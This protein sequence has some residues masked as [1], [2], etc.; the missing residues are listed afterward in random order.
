[1]RAQDLS[2]HYVTL[3]HQQLVSLLVKRDAERKL[4]L[5][6]ET[7]DI[8]PETVVGDGF[9]TLA[10]QAEDP[11]SCGPAPYRNLVVEGD[12]HVALRWLRMAY[13]GRIGAIIIDPPYNRGKRDLVYNDDYVSQTDRFRSSKW[14]NFLHARFVLARDLLADDG[15]ILVCINDE[16]RAKLELLLDEVFP[17]MRVGSF[18]WRTRG[19]ANEGGDNFFTADHEHVLIY[20][21]RGFRFGGREK[22]YEKYGNPDGDPRGDWRLGDL[23]IGVP[24]DNKRA[25]NGYYPLR[26]PGTGVWYPANPDAVWRY[27]SKELLKP[28]QRLKKQAMED[29]VAEGKVV[30]PKGNRVETWATLEDLYAAID[31]GDVPLNGVGAP[32][33]RRGLPEIEK[34]VGRRVG[35]G[36]PAFKRHKRDLKNQNQ[37]MSSWIRPNA[38]KDAVPADDVTTLTSKYNDEGTSYLKQILGAKVFDYPKPMSL[39]KELVRQCTGPTDIVLDFFGGSGTTGEAVLTV[40]AEDDTDRRFIL[41]S[42]TEATQK[43]PDRNICRDVCAERLRRV[44]EGHGRL[45]GLAGGFGYA[46]ADT[47][48]MESLFWDGLDAAQTWLAIQAIH[49]VDLAPLR[50]GPAQWCRLLDGSFVLYVD[51]MTADIADWAIRE[52]AGS[53]GTVYVRVPGPARDAFS[54]SGGVEVRRLPDAIVE[55]FQR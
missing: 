48:P 35:W 54:A 43:D 10:L 1:M 52:F 41:V 23:T 21:K 30:F 40:N 50:P 28:G 5:V 14:L 53:A 11:R 49:G 8:D 34:W 42:S 18:V 32:L 2:A 17:G 25:G 27:A 13:A 47:A 36:T 24:W 3:E 38:D 4:G 20:A 31:A 6:W 37:P 16:N 46:V 45:P 19:G 26:D 51:R 7:S 39:M 44:I 9:T 55:R 33:L 15:A 29:Y 12:N 22:T